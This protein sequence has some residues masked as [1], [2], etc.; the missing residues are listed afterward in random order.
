MRAE[1]TGK[2]GISSLDLLGCDLYRVVNRIQ[3]ASFRIHVH[4]RNFW[5]LSHFSFAL[6]SN[7][8]E[9]VKGG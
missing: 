9:R 2:N 8:F 7:I 4:E 3:R 1:S 6:E 5:R